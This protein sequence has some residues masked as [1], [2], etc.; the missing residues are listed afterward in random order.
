MCNNL[1]LDIIP[2]LTRQRKYC[3]CSGDLIQCQGRHSGLPHVKYTVYDM[4]M[5]VVCCAWWQHIYSTMYIHVIG[6]DISY[7][8]TRVCVEQSGIKG[9]THSFSIFW[10]PTCH[11][12]AK[13]LISRSFD[14]LRK[15]PDERLKVSAKFK[16]A[17]SLWIRWHVSTGVI[18]LQMKPQT[19][20]LRR[21][22]VLQLPCR[23]SNGHL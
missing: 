9:R 13:L 11:S 7:L 10:A 16:H 3:I 17:G 20:C 6:V 1:Q 2:Q 15:N 14:F 18:D 5:E 21:R 12:L 23:Q 19:V 22:A 8:T 4:M